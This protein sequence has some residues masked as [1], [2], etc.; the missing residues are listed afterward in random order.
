MPVSVSDANVCT[1]SRELMVLFM[2]VP[3]L[4]VKSCRLHDRYRTGI[5]MLLQAISFV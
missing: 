1:I 5:R 2:I 4:C 3:F